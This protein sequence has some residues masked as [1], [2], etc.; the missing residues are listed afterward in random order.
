MPIYH[1]QPLVASL[2]SLLAIVALALSFVMLSSQWLKNHV[3]AFA[4]ESW[5]IAALSAAV[6]Y[7]SHFYELYIIAALTALFRGSLLPY[8][9]LRLVRRLGMDREFTSILRPS[10]SMVLGAAL[11]IVAFAVARTLGHRLHLA[12]TLVILAL[13]CMFG[14]KLVGFLLMVLRSEAISHILGLLVIENGI[15]LGSQILVPGMPLL[16]E[17]VILFDLLIIVLTFGVLVRYLKI[18]AGTTSSRQ[19]QRL[20][21]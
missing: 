19:L 18:H 6:G 1:L 21:G 9:I 8:L 20:V 13:T 16:L 14:L 11:V 15:F 12:D 3:Y 10:S 17:L 5:V 7:Y 2:F 4:L